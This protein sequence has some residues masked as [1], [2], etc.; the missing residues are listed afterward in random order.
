MEEPSDSETDRKMK[1]MTNGYIQYL[2]TDIDIQVG[3]LMTNGPSRREK[4]GQR[5]TDI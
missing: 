1:G 3:R 2:L 4:G 5:Q